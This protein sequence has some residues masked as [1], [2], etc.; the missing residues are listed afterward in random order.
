MKVVDLSVV[1]EERAATSVVAGT[2]VTARVIVVKAR[3]NP[4]IAEVK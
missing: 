4:A 2:S 1:T 3:T